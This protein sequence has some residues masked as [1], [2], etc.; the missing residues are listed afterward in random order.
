MG[1]APIHISFYL[2][3]HR[4][5]FP[6]ARII[7][8]RGD[9]LVFGLQS[10]KTQNA[11]IAPAITALKA[12]PQS[13]V[14]LHMFSNSGSHTASLLARAWRD[15]GDKRIANN[16]EK[17]G[18]ESMETSLLP[19]RCMLLDST[20]SIG[21]WAT[22]YDGTAHYIVQL[23]FWIRPALWLLW[24]VFTLYVFGWEFVSRKPNVWL[25]ASLDLNDESLLPKRAPRVYFYS[26]EDKLV[27]V[28][29]VKAHFAAAQGKGMEVDP[30]EFTGSAHVRHGKGEGEARYWGIVEEVVN[31]VLERRK[32]RIS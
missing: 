9:P 15:G 26:R 17:A 32:E 6:T 7:L 1:A 30:E 3:K 22:S 19:V 8:I 24:L 29:D 5:L 31:N 12:E 16:N 4:D 27:R 10:L 2:Q 28:R 18:K 23:P 14:V 20:P 11:R 13:P 25:E 21:D